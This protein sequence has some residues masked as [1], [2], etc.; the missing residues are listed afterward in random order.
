MLRKINHYSIKKCRAPIAEHLD[1]IAP[2][3]IDAWRA[4]SYS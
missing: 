3:I 1:K 2:Q 4:I